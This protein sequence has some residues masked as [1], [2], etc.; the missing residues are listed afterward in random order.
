MPM[1][2]RIIRIMMRTGIRVLIPSAGWRILG[3]T[4]IP[5]RS[6]SVSAGWHTSADTK[7]KNRRFLVFVCFRWF[8]WFRNSIGERRTRNQKRARKHTKTKNLRF[9]VFVLAE[10]CQPAET[11]NRRFPVSVSPRICQPAPSI[12]I[13]RPMG[14]VHGHQDQDAGGFLE[15]QCVLVCPNILK[16]TMCFLYKPEFPENRSLHAKT[17]SLEPDR[18]RFP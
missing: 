1:G 15:N 8:F 2:I 17:K 5:N 11:K 6:F 4:E 18:T 12:G 9:L 3:D 13:L 14:N 7:T 10:I 16:H